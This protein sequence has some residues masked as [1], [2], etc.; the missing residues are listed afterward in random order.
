MGLDGVYERLADRGL[1][2]GERFRG[3]CSAWRRGDQSFVEI[4]LSAPADELEGFAIHPALL[5]AALHVLVLGV[6]VAVLLPARAVFWRGSFVLQCAA[7][8]FLAVSTPKIA[9]LLG[10]VTD[11]APTAL[12]V[13]ITDVIW[14]GLLVPPATWLLRRLPPLAQFQETGE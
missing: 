10:R 8:A 1:S 3:L 14:A 6:P 4:R 5:D 9:A 7:A 13:T 2:Y 11:Q 12:S